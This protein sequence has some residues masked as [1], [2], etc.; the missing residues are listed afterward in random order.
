MIHLFLAPALLLASPTLAADAPLAA[1][2]ADAIPLA[3]RAGFLRFGPEVAVP[4]AAPLLLERFTIGDD[5]PATRAALIE[6]LPRTGGEWA[7]AIAPLLEREADPNV[8]RLMV[9][10]MARAPWEDARDV[11]ALGFTDTDPMVREMSAWVCGKQLDV[12]G[13][14]VPTLLAHLSDADAGVRGRSARS[15]GMIGDPAA[16]IALAELASADAVGSV[17]LHALRGLS[18]IDAEAAAALPELDALTRDVDPKVARLAQK[19]AD[20]R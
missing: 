16:A 13:E 10:V 12:S 5:D 8:R 11:V 6:A 9:E 17:R 4:E 3:T 19:I 2:V 15:L 1:V 14:M 7:G 20:G 18:R